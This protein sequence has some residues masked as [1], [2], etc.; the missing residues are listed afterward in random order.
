MKKDTFTI[1]QGGKIVSCNEKQEIW[2]DK[3]ILIS[4]GKIKKID[5]FDQL[6]KIAPES[7]VIDCHGLVIYPG[8]VNTHIHCAQS[9]VRGMAEDLGRAPSYTSSVPQGDDLTDEESYVFSMLGAAT[10]LRFGSTTI[11]DNYANAMINA[12]A[13]ENLG[14]RAIVSERVHD[15]EFSYL[16]ENKYIK[17]E[18]LGNELLEK[19]IFLLEKYSNVN[20]RITACLGPHAVDTCSEEL[21][22]KISDLYTKFQVPIT[23]HLAQSRQ[24]LERVQSEYGMNS[25]QVL[26][27][28]G[29][30]NDSLLAAHGVFLSES[31]VSILADSHANMIHIPEGNGKAG[32]IAAVETFVQKGINV[33]IATDNGSANMIENMRIALILGRIRHGSVEWP[34]PEMLLPMVTLQAAKA[35][36]MEHS[37]GSI[38]EGKSADLILISYDSL[39]MT[40]CMNVYGNLVHLGMGSDIKA[41]MVDGELVVK[42]GHITTIDESELIKD[43]RRIAR[44]KWYGVDASINEKKIVMI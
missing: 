31:E 30:A 6:I 4:N 15:M 27:D 33:A 36:H 10:A 41:V 20:G 19:N 2:D 21:L 35:V 32:S 29:L 42:E 22:K 13:F 34:K 1:M 17:N 5:S 11:S 38:E 25:T 7:T 3:S 16:A 39:H 23:T 9:I 12:K 14:I 43:A 18:K 8:F 37:L 28:C 40:P 26:R 44:Y 24:E